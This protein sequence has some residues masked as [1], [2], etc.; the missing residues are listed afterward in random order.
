RGDLCPAGACDVPTECVVDRRA[1]HWVEADCLLHPVY[2]TPHR[3]DRIAHAFRELAHCRFVWWGKILS[4]YGIVDDPP[5]PI[6]GW[7][8]EV[9]VGECSLIGVVAPAIKDRLRITV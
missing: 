6:E 5:G 3:L 9:H 7:I 2:T 1:G 8:P 4:I